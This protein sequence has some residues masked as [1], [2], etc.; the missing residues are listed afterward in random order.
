[1]RI[2]LRVVNVLF[3]ALLLLLS[4]TILG[5]R[6]HGSFPPAGSFPYGA[7]NAHDGVRSEIVDTLSLF[8]E[9]YIERDPAALEP[10]VAR[11][12]SPANIVILGTMPNE[13]YLGIDAASDLVR[14]DWQSWGDCRFDLENAHVSADG[15]TAWF[16]TIGYVEFD[17]SSL[18]VLPLR[19]SGVLVRE[20]GAWRFQQLQFQFDLDLSLLILMNVVLSIW[21]AIQLIGLTVVVTRHLR[22]REQAA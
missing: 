18:L 19:L 8:Q 21:L 13:I 3:V 12:L 5:D 7:G 10:F 4:T 9:G 16:S 11:L 2:A 1:M 20:D 15:D 17:L 14:T 6:Y 22:R